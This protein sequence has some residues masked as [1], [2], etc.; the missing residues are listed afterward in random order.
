MRDQQPPEA[1]YRTQA[2][3]GPNITPRHV[4]DTQRRVACEPVAQLHILERVA[5][6]NLQEQLWM[7]TDAGSQAIGRRK[8]ARC[9]R[10]APECSARDN[11]LDGALGDEQ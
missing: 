9:L 11:P 3:V 4:D 8:L 1:T 6:A 10:V 7:L 2:V 5:R